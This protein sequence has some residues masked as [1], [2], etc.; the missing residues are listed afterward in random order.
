MHRFITTHADMDTAPVLCC[1]I[2]G[3]GKKLAVLQIDFQKSFWAEGRRA[4]KSGSLRKGRRQHKYIPLVFM[5]TLQQEHNVNHDIFWQCS[6]IHCLIFK[7]IS[8]PSLKELHSCSQLPVI[9]VEDSWRTPWCHAVRLWPHM[10]APHGFPEGTVWLDMGAGA[11][12]RACELS[13]NLDIV[14]PQGK[15]HHKC[16]VQCCLHTIFLSNSLM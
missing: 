1:R 6:Q 4:L 8:Q 7:Y 5:L 3:A 14:S 11:C 10:C 16:W 2:K 13:L 12:R 15:T 9:L